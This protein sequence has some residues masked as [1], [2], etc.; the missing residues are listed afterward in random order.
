[1]PISHPFIERLIGTLRREY[2]DW[3]LFWGQRANK[4]ALRWRTRRF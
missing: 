4:C 1:V 3:V 2:L